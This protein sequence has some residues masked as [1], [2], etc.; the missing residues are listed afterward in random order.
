M[1]VPLP[2]PGE[3]KLTRPDA[4][5]VAATARGIASVVAPAGGLTDLQRM[6]LEALFPAMTEYHVDLSH[7]EPMSVDELAEVLRP[8]DLA[9]RTRGVQI[10]LLA[11]LVLRPLPP[12]VAARVA[13]LAQILG[14]DESMVEVA[15]LFAAGSLGLAAVDFERNG[16]TADWHPDD[17]HELHTSSE[18]ASAWDLAV[19]DPPLA[20]RWA[21]LGSLPVETLGHGVWRL[22]QARGFVFPGLP[23]SAPPLL[24]QHDWVHVLGDYGTRVESEVEV[25]AL[26]ARANDDMRA[27]SLLAMVVS[28]FETGY[29]RTGAGL[30]HSDLGH[31]SGHSA[32]RA[33]AIR[34][35]DAMRRGAWCHDRERGSD[36]VDFLRQDWFALASLP[37][38]EV[39]ARFGLRPKSPEATSA[40]SVGPW[41]SGGISPFQ[42]K[43]GRAMAAQQE[44]EYASYGASP[45]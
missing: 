22:Y 35:A 40:G 29:L 27:F 25:F 39:R 6:L 33:M 8:R 13:S 2:G 42:L 15:Q 21:A 10:A 32:G 19:H 3:A 24:A 4:A 41:V 11:A 7:F 44:R 31:L 1:S 20:E 26:I 17:R 37:L 14:V 18:L 30:F 28:L 16:Y 36:S 12:D 23:G 9:F 34:L 5:E 38:D 43:A 45:D